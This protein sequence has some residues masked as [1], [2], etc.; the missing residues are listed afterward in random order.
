[1]QSSCKCVI[2]IL[3]MHYIWA[4]YD[5]CQPN[6]ILHMNISVNKDFLKFLSIS[7]LDDMAYINA[8]LV[9]ICTS[10]IFFSLSPDIALHSRYNKNTNWP[11]SNIAMCVF[12]KTYMNAKMVNTFYLFHI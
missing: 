4:S 8:S 6:M 1:M 10:K 2:F 7:Y 9:N 12:H 11:T 5:T 3:S